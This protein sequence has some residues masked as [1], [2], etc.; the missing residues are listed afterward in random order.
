MK[1]QLLKNKKGIIFGALD[2]RSIA[3]KTALKVYDEG[4]EAILTNAPVALRM[5]K[6]SE[7]AKKLDTP[8][9]A[10]DATSIDDLEKLIDFSLNHFG[11][12]LDFIL[13][14]IGMSINLRKKREY[15]DLNHEWTTKG[16]DISALS[17]HKLL[18][19]LFKKNA[20]KE[21]GSVIALSYIAAQRTFPNYNDM[22]DNKAYLESVARS[23]GYYMGKERKVRVNTISQSPTPTTAGDGVKGLNSFLNFAEKISPLGNASSDDC[24][25]FSVVMFSDY[26]KKITMQNIFHDGGFSSVGISQDLI[27]IIDQEQK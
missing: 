4:G 8:A 18:Q 24:A 27:D 11:Q 15:T 17:F 23:F 19:I 3:W 13:H 22:A 5:G 7:L 26:T 1:N 2:E 6:I 12:K 16:W 20:L 14:S 9:I 25:N 21:W 10:A